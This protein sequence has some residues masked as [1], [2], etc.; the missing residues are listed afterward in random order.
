MSY[1]ETEHPL[2]WKRFER[3]NKQNQAMMKMEERNFNSREV[4]TENSQ[5]KRFFTVTS[6]EKKKTIPKQS[7]TGSHLMMKRFVVHVT[8]AASD[9]L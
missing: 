1:I 7:N 5:C 8:R 2:I 4:Q 9:Q 3:D 6:D